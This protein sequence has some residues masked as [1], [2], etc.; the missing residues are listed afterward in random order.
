MNSTAS[1][2]SSSGCDGALAHLAEV[3][4]RADDA[5]AEVM[6]PDPVDHHARGQR[7]VGRDEP[8]REA[9]AAPA[10]WS[11]R[12]AAAGTPAR[13][14]TATL[15]TPGV[16][17]EPFASMLPRCRK[18]DGPR[19]AARLRR[20]R[21]PWRTAS[22]SSRSIAAIWA[23]S[24]ACFACTSVGHQRDDVL[25]GDLG[26]QRCRSAASSR[27]GRRSAAAPRCA[28]RAASST[29]VCRYSGSCAIS[30]STSCLQVRRFEF[31]LRLLQR[32]EQRLDPRRLRAMR[33]RP[34]A[35]GTSGC[36]TGRVDAKTAWMR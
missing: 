11:R 17:T 5:L 36:S 15:S 13:V 16:I 9:A 6:L 29:R 25:L 18:Y 23:L 1:Q 4:R 30:R 31:P 27:S 12:P 32:L 14:S 20:W 26:A 34:R 19:L 10:R 22:A 3:A 33:L 28:R 7:V 24:A 2:S 35:P 8:L 21:A